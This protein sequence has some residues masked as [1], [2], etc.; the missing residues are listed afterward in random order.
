MGEVEFFFNKSV[1]K[2]ALTNIFLV[3]LK[4]FKDKI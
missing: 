2:L 1:Q 3:R 4:L